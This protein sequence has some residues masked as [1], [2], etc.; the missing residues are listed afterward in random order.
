[1]RATVTNTKG[2]YFYTLENIV[3]ITY[4]NKSIIITTMRDGEI[5]T[6]HYSA[7]V[8]INIVR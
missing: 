4:V 2:D 7:E 6:H 8:I 1:M 3:A 5:L